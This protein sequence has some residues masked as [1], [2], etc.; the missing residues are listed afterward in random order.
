MLVAAE[1]YSAA[2]CD[3]GDLHRVIDACSRA[4]SLLGL[5]VYEIGIF[6][7]INCVRHRLLDEPWPLF[8]IVLPASALHTNEETALMG[9]KQISWE[10]IFYGARAK[11]GMGIGAHLVERPHGIEAF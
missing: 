7:G 8:P 1:G 5:H 3:R 11:Q 10:Q 9:A 6:I 2:A 4:T